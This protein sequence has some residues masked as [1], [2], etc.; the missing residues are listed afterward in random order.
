MPL[1]KA[2]DQTPAKIPIAIAEITTRLRTL[3]RHT[4]RH[5]TEKIMIF[6]F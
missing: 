4:F 3:F 2:A 6:D 1:K 5:E